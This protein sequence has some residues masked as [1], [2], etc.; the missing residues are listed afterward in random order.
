[1][2]DATVTK[3]PDNSISS[4]NR[5]KLYPDA[6]VRPLPKPPELIDKRAEPT[7]CIGS[8]P[9]MDFEENSPHQE[10]GITS[11]MHINL[12]QSYFKKP[13]KLIDLV[14]TS[15]LVQNYLPGQMDI[16]KILDV[17]MRKVLKGTHLPLTIKKIWAGYLTSLYFKD[18]YKYLA[19]NDLPRK[20]CVVQKVEALSE[21][22]IPLNSLLFKLITTPGKE[23]ALLAIPELCTD[24]IIT[25]YHASLF[26]GHQGVIQTYLTISDKF[27][28]PNLIHYLRS[29]LKACYVCQLAANEKPPS[30]QLQTR[31]NLN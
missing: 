30:R 28:I 7:Q 5:G 27:F 3:T 12:D 25:L 8:T 1:M 21:R 13:K 17:I 24:K 6:I 14:D 26:A 4:G 23:K 20:R 15:K 18:I 19:Q 2:Q 16:D 31:I 10:E 29:Y 11:E 22:F 9:N